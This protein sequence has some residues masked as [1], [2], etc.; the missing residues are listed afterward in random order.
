MRPGSLSTKLHVKLGETQLVGK[1]VREFGQ[2]HDV[3]EEALFVVNL[4]LDEVVTNIVTHSPKSPPGAKE[5]LIRLSTEHGE[6]SAEVEDDG[7]AFNPLNL[8]APDICA[9]L[10]DRPAGGM[11]VHLVRSLMDHVD[12]RRIGRR[13]CFTMTKR[14]A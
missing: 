3:P 11:G 8:P 10:Q 9:S 4:S 14:V 2:W 13:N 6:V 5:I 7:G 1:M 12:Y